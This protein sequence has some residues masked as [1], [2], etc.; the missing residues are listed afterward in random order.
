M[1]IQATEQKKL[2][3]GSKFNPVLKII[4]TQRIM[5]FTRQNAMHLRNLWCRL[6][7]N[8]IYM[9]I[10]T[11]HLLTRTFLRKPSSSLYC[12]AVRTQPP[13]NAITSGKVR[14]G[15]CSGT[16]NASSLRAGI[17][18]V[19]PSLAR[20]SSS[21]SNAE[22]RSDSEFTSCFQLKSAQPGADFYDLHFHSMLPWQPSGIKS[23]WDFSQ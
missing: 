12:L 6:I 10:C 8:V 22:I 15:N 20:N 17:P 16:D 7:K 3:N 23:S 21:Q 14:A 11:Y 1:H 4:C 19:L 18:S 13:G 2:S 9:Y 5:H